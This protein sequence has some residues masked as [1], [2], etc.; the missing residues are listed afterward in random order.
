MLM[1]I[2]QNNIV[3][4]SGKERKSQIRDT[5]FLF[6]LKATPPLPLPSSVYFAVI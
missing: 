1:L 3:L 6:R 2:L 4:G 5:F